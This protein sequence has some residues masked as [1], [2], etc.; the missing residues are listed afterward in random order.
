MQVRVWDLPL[1]LF[2]WLLVVAVTGSL[3][4]IY[5]GGTWMV[6]HERFGLMVLGLLVFRVLWGLV[7]STHAR[8]SEFL[9]TPRVMLAYLRGRWHGAGHTPV[10]GL[11][12]LVMLGLFGF[13]ALS[14]LVATDDI[15]FSGPLRNLVSSSLS[16]TLSSWHRWTEE[17][18]Y[19][20]IG[21]HILAIAFYQLRGKKLVGAMLH[22]KKNV[23]R[24]A[25][26]T[27]NGGWIA[28]VVVVVISGLAIWAASGAWIPAP[29][30][31]PAAPAW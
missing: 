30:P 11:S 22:G 14:G 19:V 28:L 17:L 5:L 21:L 16:N 29:A 3:V 18:I 27:R 4:S 6:W 7:G 1:R 2:H 25:S 8:F 31:A 23:S 26:D 24:P 20:V 13:Q 10:G 15:A 9:P 12:V